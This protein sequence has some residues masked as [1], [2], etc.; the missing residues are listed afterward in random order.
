MMYLYQQNSKVKY[1]ENNLAFIFKISE[2][3]SGYHS[4]ILNR[5]QIFSLDN[6]RLI[7]ELKWE[8]L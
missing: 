4:Y 1:V 2:D 5:Y 8:V 7:K 3:H 6:N